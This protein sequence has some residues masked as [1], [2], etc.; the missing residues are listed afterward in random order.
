MEARV[1]EPAQH[2]EDHR[3]GDGMDD[4]CGLHGSHTA[5]DGDSRTAQSPA[6]K[7]VDQKH[8]NFFEH[9]HCL[10]IKT[11]S[12]FYYV[13]RFQLNIGAGKLSAIKIAASHTGAVNRD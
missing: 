13:I 7:A 4:Q 9:F 2:G 8:S 3:R 5:A 6:N 11:Y 10:S 12:I 1:V